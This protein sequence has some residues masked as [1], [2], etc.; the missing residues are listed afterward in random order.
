MEFMVMANSPH[1]SGPDET[2]IEDSAPPAASAAL[3]NAAVF[4]AVV[5]GLSLVRFFKEIFSPL[6]VATFLLLLIDALSRDMHRRMPLAPGW[7]RR[8]VAGI[9]TLLGF[10]LIVGLFVVEGPPFAGELR[11]LAPKIDTLLSRVMAMVG[12]PAMTL[13][14]M[15]SGADPARIL[16]E[17]FAT[18]RSMISYAVLVIIYFGFLVASRATFS[19]KVDGLYDSDDQRQ[20]AHRVLTSVR[21]AVE[22]YVRLQT[23]KALMI[24]IAAYIL[25]ALM[26]VQHRLFVAFL[27]FLSAYVPIVGA[28][29]GSA[30]PSLLALSQFDGVA[31]PVALM[32]VLGSAVF[33]IDNVVMPK[34]QSDELNLDPLLVLISIG[35]WA[36]ILGAPGVL[37]S[38]PLTVTVMAI[39]AEF[40]SMRWLAIMLSRDGEPVKTKAEA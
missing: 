10:G 14:Q 21:N 31:R 39:C 17:V 5:L 27:V 30:F 2:P 8:G 1:P 26:G 33:L 38:T 40:P 35:F 15:F 11:G 20:S 34:L 19:R 6:V 22:R 28:F 32:A 16:S 7:M 29:I 24:A 23:M 36:A 3:R 4:M 25:M 13:R 37:L 9:I 12:A 18:A